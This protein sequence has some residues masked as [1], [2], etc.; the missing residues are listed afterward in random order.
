MQWIPLIKDMRARGMPLIVDLSAEDLEDFMKVMDPRG[1][2]L[3]VATENEQQE[4]D[5]LNRLQKWT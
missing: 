4:L 2:F 5:I 1:L 3:W